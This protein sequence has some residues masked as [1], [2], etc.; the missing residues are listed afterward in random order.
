VD[1][2]RRRDPLELTTTGLLV[3][4]AKCV[5]PAEEAAWDAWEDD[6]HLPALCTGDGPWAATRFE[7]TARPQ[8]GLPGPGFTHVTIHE[9]DAD[10]ARAQ[11]ATTLDRDDALRAAGLVHP[12]HA[13]IAADVFVAHGRFGTKPPP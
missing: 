8:P 4:Y 9:L 12:A 5:R 10:D 6:V 3:V 7:L 13:T 1:R 11:A 2:R